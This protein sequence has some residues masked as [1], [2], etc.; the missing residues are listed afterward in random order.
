MTATPAPTTRPAT[1]SASEQP[2]FATDGSTIENPFAFLTTPDP[3]ETTQASNGGG[4]AAPTQPAPTATPAP[5]VSNLPYCDTSGA[6]NPP[7]GSV[8]GLV[9]IGGEPAPAGTIVF[10]AFDGVIGPSEAVTVEGNQAGYSLNY[11]SGGTDCANQ[12]GASISVVVAGQTF[13]TGQT[14]GGAPVALLF[15]V[16]AN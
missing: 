6:G 11:S 10:L 16:N 8:L 2:G 12:A 1:R 9:T 4:P 7:T 5:S 15:N 14:V 13:S 3:E